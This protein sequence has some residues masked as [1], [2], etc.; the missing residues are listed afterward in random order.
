M[1][2]AKQHFPII[3]RQQKP[4]KLFDRV[5]KSVLMNRPEERVRLQWVDYA[6][7]E[8]GFN[9]SKISVEKGLQTL[10]QTDTKRYDVVLYNK[11]N[12]PEI[13]IECK[14]PHISLSAS[15]AMQAARYNQ[16]LQAETIILTNG[17]SD[18]F[19]DKDGSP[20]TLSEFAHRYPTKSKIKWEKEYWEQRGF[21]SEML[22]DLEKLRIKKSLNILRYG[23]D[24]I[25]FLEHKAPIWQPYSYYYFIDREE[26]IQ[27]AR[28]FFGL[29]T[30]ITKI[31]SILLPQYS[32]P[33]MIFS[34]IHSDGTILHFRSDGY[35]E[36]EL[37]YNDNE[38]LSSPEKIFNQHLLFFKEL[39]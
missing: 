26:D 15:T 10:K 31:V 34:E 36:I 37:E 28:T 27:R 13:L 20:L 4:Y 25:R 35:E 33:T 9:L 24:D 29:P 5:N 14:A 39:A 1:S 7:Y 21:I 8:L 16:N 30:D 18:L 2:L 23:V 17:R 38:S 11:D 32:Q 12:M 6:F 22:P 3:S 19:F